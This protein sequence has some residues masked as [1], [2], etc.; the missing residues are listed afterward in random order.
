MKTRIF[1]LIIVFSSVLFIAYFAVSN[2]LFN[3]NTV[4]A[5]GDL[6]VDFHVPIG[7]PIFVVN[8]M[9]P[10]DSQDRDVDV[11]NS[12]VLTR[13]VSVKGI[14][15]SGIGSDPKI[16]TVLDLVIKDGAT[17][18]YG[19]GSTTGSKTLANFFTESGSADGVKLNVINPGGH[20][21]YN[22]KVTFPTSAG[23]EFQAKSVTFD[24]TFGVLTGDNVVINEVFYRVD[25]AHGLDSPK[26][27][28]VNG[29]KLG[30]NDEWVELFNPTDH[31]INLK[32]YG[33]VDNSGILVK[34]NGNRI[35]GSE[36][37]A[38]VAKD[39]GTW[40]AW[41]EPGLVL[42]IPLGRQ[43]GDGLDNGG[44]RL[45]L[46][47][48]SGNTID[49]LSWGSDTS[50]FTIPNVVVGHSLE[51]LVPGFDTNSPLDF[52]DRVNPTPGS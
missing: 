9:A 37:F 13:F 12:G 3:P 29:N 49:A 15:T 43:I 18:I 2:S 31:D 1:K 4:K 27:R 5:F 20:K 33:F 52:I 6:T 51:R 26:N 23:N 39:N 19:T 7:N 17:P 44:D 8:N 14:R 24:L 10:G 11:T 35:L 48:A 42:K 25:G 30:I 41:S 46:K 50:I 32:N 16:E 45:L 34:I 47:D 22:F 36:K 21:I 38:L 28:V 40:N